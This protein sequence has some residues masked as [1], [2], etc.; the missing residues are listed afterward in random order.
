MRTTSKLVRS[1]VSSESLRTKIKLCG[2]KT[3][4]G[5]WNWCRSPGCD[6]CRKHRARTNASVQSEWADQDGSY[7]IQKFETATRWCCDPDDLLNEINVVRTRLR[8]AIDRRQTQNA[9]WSSVKLNGMFSPMFR[10]G[11]WSASL[12]GIIHLGRLHEVTFLDAIDPVLRVRLD[13]FPSCILKR[14][15][16][17]HVYWTIS[18]LHG[19]R[20]CDEVN[21]C[22]YFSAINRRG[23][24]KSLI[25]RRGFQGES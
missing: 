2:T 5:F 18:S 21:L 12:R 14:D 11:M 19:L 25:F 4:D 16:F 15:V 7:R 6:R 24:Y 10:D 9:R 8:K 23:G 3:P 17:D 22:V 13:S 1:E 20:G